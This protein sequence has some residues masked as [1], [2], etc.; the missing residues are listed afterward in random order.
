MPTPRSDDHLRSRVALNPSQVI[1]ISN[2]S[3]TVFFLYQIPFARNLHK[4]E[5]LTP[6]TND[7]N[8][9]R[10]KE[11]VDTHTRTQSQQ[12]HAHKSRRECNNQNNGVI[13]Q[14]Y[15]QISINETI[16]WSRSLGVK[17]CSRYACVLLQGA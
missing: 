5:S 8:Q 15:A 10:S 11:G 2:L 12:Q 9:N 3:T 16:E 1:Q 4:L 13:T 7:L 17:V 14:E 6:Y